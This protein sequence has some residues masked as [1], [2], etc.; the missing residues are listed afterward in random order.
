MG[1]EIGQAEGLGVRDEQAKHTPPGG[2][3]PYSGFLV[4]VQSNSDEFRQSGPVIIEHAERTEASPGHGTG[5]LDHMAE[6]YRQLEVL[7]N[8][9][10]RLEDPPELAWIL[11]GVIR[12]KIAGY[13][14]KPAYESEFF[15]IERPGHPGCRRNGKI[16]T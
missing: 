6:E 13:Q 9:Q 2:T 3:D 7:L 16:G 1:I 8:E 12:H 5:L 10:G 11:N 15:V 4:W 14:G